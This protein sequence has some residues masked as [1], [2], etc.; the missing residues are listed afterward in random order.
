MVMG[1]MF[2]CVGLSPFNA[3]SSW[4]KKRSRPAGKAVGISGVWQRSVP[5]NRRRSATIIGVLLSVQTVGYRGMQSSMCALVWQEF[6]IRSKPLCFLYKK[7]G[8]WKKKSTSVR[9]IT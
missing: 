1:P 6:D 2:F 3:A 4:R 8:L 9:L 5:V 7:Y